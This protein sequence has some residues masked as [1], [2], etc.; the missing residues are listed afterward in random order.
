MKTT[1]NTR[2][3][4][5]I[6]N[7]ILWNWLEKLLPSLDCVVVVLCCCCFVLFCLFCLLFVCFVCVV[8]CFV[9]FV[10]C[11]V[12]FVLFVLVCVGLNFDLS[13]WHDSVSSNRLLKNIHLKR[14][15]IQTGVKQGMNCEVVEKSVN[16]SIWIIIKIMKNEKQK[17]NDKPIDFSKTCSR[18]AKVWMNMAWQWHDH[19]LN[20]RVRPHSFGNPIMHF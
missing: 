20:T 10:V 18:L 19:Q 3:P 8:V 17:R 15:R 5:Q 16:K 11:V 12:L 14:R 13:I 1:R 7:S 9:C 6:K 4:K 2:W